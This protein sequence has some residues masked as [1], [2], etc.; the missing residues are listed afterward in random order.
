[1]RPLKFNSL[2]FL[3]L[4]SLNS[5]ALPSD[6]QEKIFIIANTWLY[7]YKTGV[8]IYEGNVKIDQGT[9]HIRADKLITKRNKHHKIKEATAYGMENAAKFWTTPKKDDPLIHATAKII[10]FSP[11]LSNV[12]FKQNVVIQ[13]KE[14]TFHGE[15]IHYNKNAQ[16][17][18]VPASEHA[19]AVIVYNPNQ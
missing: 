18:T 16:T 6:K 1:M 13:Q 2:L 11:L 10:I 19:R 15:L 7:N 12:T 3:L 9:T 4:L 5:L 14:N 8:D 17:I